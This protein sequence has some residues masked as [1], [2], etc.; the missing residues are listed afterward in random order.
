MDDIRLLAGLERLALSV[1]PLVMRA[2]TEG[3][4]VDRKADDSPVTHADR[5]SERLI[6]AGLRGLCPTTPVVAEES[7]AAGNFPADPGSTFFL[8]DPLD[9][10]R[11]F[12][13]GRPEFTVNIG[14]V[15]AGAPVLGV[16]YA[17]AASVL[18]AGR[19]GQA[20]R[21]T[22]DAQGGAVS[23]QVISARPRTAHVSVVASR[24]HR[25]LETDRYIA[26]LQQAEI[27]AVGSS[28]KFGLL[29]AGE[30]DLYPR[31]GR[32]MQWDTAAGGAVLRAAGGITETLDGRPLAYGPRGSDPARLYENPAFVARG[33]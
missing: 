33:L 12:I 2:F 25:V 21:V 30:A 15:R 18:Y 13:A 20:E 22:V 24:S 8:V 32:T 29:A 11:E 1:G 7:V 31:F 5:E 28:L 26:T 9:G 17:P 27:V 3:C 23:R 14:L 6:L 19:P 10:T 16:V 4:A